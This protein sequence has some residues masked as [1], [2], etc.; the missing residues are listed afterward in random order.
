[1]IV[2]LICVLW[3]FSVPAKLLVTLLGVM[4]KSAYN[5][6]RINGYTTIL[7]P[8]SLSCANN[9]FIVVNFSSNQISPEIND[10]ITIN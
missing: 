9:F 7:S 10:F 8:N 5:R 1:M 4:T 2:T 3:V 6:N